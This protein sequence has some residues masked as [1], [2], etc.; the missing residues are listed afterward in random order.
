M[1]F[2]DTLGTSQTSSGSFLDSLGKK[3]P[4]K[5][6]SLAD[7][8][9][10][11]LSGYGQNV[12]STLQ[13]SGDE[14]YNKFNEQGV[15]SAERGINAVGAVAGGAISTVASAI[16]GAEA[17]GKIAG[18][19][20]GGVG[21]GIGSIPAVQKAV[22]E[23]PDVA[24]GVE[25]AANVGQSLGNVASV[26]LAGE[27]IARG[28][29]AAVDTIKDT[30]NTVRGIN[31]VSDTLKPEVQHSAKFVDDHVTGTPSP[32]MSRIQDMISPKLT[33]KETK[34]ALDQGRIIPGQ[35]PTLLKSGTPD[36]VLPSESTVRAAKTIR[37]TIPEA[38]KMKAPELYK[39]LDSKINTTAKE[40]RPN[41]EAVPITQDTV[42]LITDN[43]KTVKAQQLNDPYTPTTANLEKL[44]AQFEQVLKE[45]KSGTFADLWDSRVRYDMSVPEAVKNANP[46]SS[47]VLQAQKSAWLQ[48]RSILNDAIETASSGLGTAARQAFKMMND[49]YNAQRGIQSSYKV[50][51]QGALSGVKQ[52]AKDHPY[53]TAGVGAG[54]A[55]ATG[56]DK[57]VVG[58]ILR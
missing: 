35:D 32:E 4:A 56:L 7:S 29:Q 22:A 24:R 27:G 50:A 41:M 48:N 55:H 17:L 9:W 52:F 47:E 38:S 1:A 51:S 39:A 36:T 16:P 12:A 54:A 40:L 45:S 44:Q 18:G 11:K 20:I 31:T 15:S 49:L 57:A 25:R 19:V 30:T 21:Q 8:I 43:W 26:A 53:I 33:A 3:P 37:E 23:H 6:P 14:V 10:K 34:L 5:S 46:L 2:L 42:Q 13:R 58:A 28:A